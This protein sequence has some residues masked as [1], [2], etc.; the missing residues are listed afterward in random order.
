MQSDILERTISGGELVLRVVVEVFELYWLTKPVAHSMRRYRQTA[1]LGAKG[2]LNAKDS[3]KFLLA[4][5][6]TEKFYIDGC[7]NDS[8]SCLELTNR[9]CKMYVAH[10][11]TSTHSSFITGLSRLRNVGL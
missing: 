5:F 8:N 2:L 1:S 6:C 4:A 3:R 9:G 10:K 11:R 7:G